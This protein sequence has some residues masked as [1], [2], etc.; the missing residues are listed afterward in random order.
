MKTSSLLKYL[1]LALGL[2]YATLTI[3][4][5]MDSIPLHGTLTEIEGFLIHISPGLIIA[6]ASIYGSFRPK[7]GRLIFLVISI[8]YTLYYNT[9]KEFGTFMGISFPLIVITIILLLASLPAIEKKS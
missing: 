1:A 8:V 9:Y 4:L 5:A 7:Y 2:L 6:I 3:I